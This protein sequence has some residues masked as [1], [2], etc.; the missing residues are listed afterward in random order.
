[1]SRAFF[2]SNV[3]LYAIDLRDDRRVAAQAVV[4]RGGAVSIQ[5]LNEFV[6]VAV[7]K[8]GLSWSRACEAR[9]E[10]LACCHPVVTLTLD[11]HRAGVHWAERHRLSVYDGMIVAAALEAGCDTLWSEDM[12]HGLIVDGRLTIRNPFG[13]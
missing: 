5:C 2:D 1:M 8:L 11:L 6:S 13:G 9:D 10:L 3:L 7:R 12:H 4:A